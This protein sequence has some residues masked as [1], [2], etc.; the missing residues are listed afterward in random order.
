M[1]RRKETLGEKRSIRR[2]RETMK[3]KEFLKKAEEA[4]LMAKDCLESSNIPQII[5]DTERLVFH[6]YEHVDSGSYVPLGEEDIDIPLCE[7]EDRIPMRHID[8]YP[9]KERVAA[10][11][12]SFL[13]ENGVSV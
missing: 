11:I 10:E 7:I 1:E 13:E 3:G 6:V 12:V 5:F 9:T 4:Y 8:D 2:R